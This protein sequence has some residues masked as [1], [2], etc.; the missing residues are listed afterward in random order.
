MSN[1]IG[2]KGLLFGLWKRALIQQFPQRFVK[3]TIM[4]VWLVWCNRRSYGN[5]HW[6]FAWQNS[7]GNAFSTCVCSSQTHSCRMQKYVFMS[8]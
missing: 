6:Q 5:L 4:S 1:F 2:L 3:Q 7:K 8:V